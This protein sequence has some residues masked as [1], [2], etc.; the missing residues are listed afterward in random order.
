MS[1]KEKQVVIVRE[2]VRAGRD[3]Q[4]EERYRYGSRRKGKRTEKADE[5]WRD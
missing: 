4:E 5:K 3:R 1:T 2:R